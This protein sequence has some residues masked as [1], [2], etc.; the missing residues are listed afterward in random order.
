RNNELLAIQQEV[1]AELNRAMI[2]NVVE[3]IVEGQSKLVA[4]QTVR[5]SSNVELGWERRA[6]G[7]DLTSEQRVQLVARTRGDQVVC[8]EGSP[9]FK[10]R[11]MNVRII[12]AR[13]MTLFARQHTP[14]DAGCAA[15]V[16]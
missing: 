1:T 16:R 2:G 6:I 9:A 13:G 7:V 12:D 4:C 3:V 15:R 10:G 11:I 8:F 5:T 14:Q